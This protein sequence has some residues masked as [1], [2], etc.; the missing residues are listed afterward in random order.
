[1]LIPT[2]HSNLH[3]ICLR[4]VGTRLPQYEWND[5]K[6]MYILFLNEKVAR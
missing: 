6:N 2:I 5:P 4:H 1:M 3:S